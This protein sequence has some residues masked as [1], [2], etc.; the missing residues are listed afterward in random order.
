[1]LK[2][3]EVPILP[4]LSHVV[5]S[6]NRWATTSWETPLVRQM[7]CTIRYL[8]WLSSEYHGICFGDSRQSCSRQVSISKPTC[9]CNFGLRASAMLHFGKAPG[10]NFKGSSG[11]ALQ[12][13]PSLSTHTSHAPPRCHPQRGRNPYHPNMSRSDWPNF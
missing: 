3:Y 2:P 7:P 11:V 12:Y 8:W 5:L 13:L 4:D 6:L 1:M 9:L 10:L